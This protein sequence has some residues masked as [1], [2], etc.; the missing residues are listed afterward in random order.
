MNDTFISIDKF[1]WPR[2]EAL[3]PSPELRF[4]PILTRS[5]VLL[6]PT[7]MISRNNRRMS[8]QRKLELEDDNTSDESA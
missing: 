6:L 2:A 4:S 3:M 1:L 7:P 5:D 8:C